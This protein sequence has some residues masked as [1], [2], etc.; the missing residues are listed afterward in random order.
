MIRVTR[1]A[2]PPTLPLVRTTQLA[3]LRTLGRAP[4]TGDIDGYRIVSRELWQRQHYKCCYCERKLLESYND[5][6][7]FRPK[8]RADRSPGSTHTY[9]Y[10]WL[11]FSWENLLF[12]CP[13]C[14]RSGKNDK[15]P[16]RRSCK[17]LAAEQRPPGGEAP[18]LLDPSGRRNPACH[19]CFELRVFRNTR[20]SRWWAKAYR[21]S[22]YGAWSVEVFGLNSN[23][24]V[25]LRADY[26]DNVVYPSAK[27]LVN[28]LQSRGPGPVAQ[29]FRHA[30]ALLNPKLPYTL[31]AYDALIHYV[32]NNELRSYGLAWPRRS[33]VGS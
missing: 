1:G 6:E 9:G 16:L 23:E 28:A 27:E 19:I 12:A 32:P 8:A 15:F 17:V 11:A 18:L 29:A 22:S 2:E 21:G 3:I 5:V 4:T 7:H 25:E 20:T 10:W 31:L 24:Q 33:Q 26:V 14:N 13:T 30:A